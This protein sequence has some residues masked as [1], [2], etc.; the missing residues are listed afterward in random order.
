MKKEDVKFKPDHVPDEYLTL[1][2]YF[3]S[4]ND[5]STDYFIELCEGEYE[6]SAIVKVYSVDGIWNIFN[7]DGIKNGDYICLPEWEREC[8]AEVKLCGKY[9]FPTFK[10]DLQLYYCDEQHYGC[11]GMKSNSITSLFESI[12]YAIEWGLKESKIKPY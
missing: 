9:F 6:G 5:Y 12:N 10:N 4:E 3:K 2:I 11:E 7:I 1:G 8:F